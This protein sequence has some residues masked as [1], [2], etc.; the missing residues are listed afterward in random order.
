MQFIQR[1]NFTTIVLTNCGRAGIRPLLIRFWAAKNKVNSVGVL[2]QQKVSIGGIHHLINS[3]EIWRQ[4]VDV[5]VSQVNVSPNNMSNKAL[6]S[7]ELRIRSHCAG[8]GCN[9]TISISSSVQT[10]NCNGF[11]NHNVS[12]TIL[13]CSGKPG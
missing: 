6:Q 3:R 7:V 10:V 1:L 12:H 8:T 4:A 9:I 13:L 2:W 5:I 11:T